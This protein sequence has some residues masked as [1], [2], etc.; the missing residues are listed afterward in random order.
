MNGVTVNGRINFGPTKI[1]SEGR[2]GAARP[3]TPQA[4]QIAGMGAKT[5][6]T[7]QHIKSPGESKPNLAERDDAE[8]LTEGSTAEEQRKLQAHR[9]YPSSAGSY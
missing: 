7:G 2:K 8:T 5:T 9:W 4:S 1:V 3:S 6:M